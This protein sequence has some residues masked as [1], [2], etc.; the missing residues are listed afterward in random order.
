MSR[1]YVA[2]P[3][4]VVPV[5][6]VMLLIPY[7]QASAAELKILP[8]IWK[9][10]V[11]RTSPMTEGPTTET[12]TECVEEDTFNPT[13]MM[14]GIQGCELVSESLVDTT[15]HYKMA[16]TH[17]DAIVTIEGF[18]QTDGSTGKGNMDMKMNMAGVKVDMN[19]HWAGKRIGDC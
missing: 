16:C 6:M 10:V 13:R 3:D 8:G 18:Y 14:R 11:T 5:V 2:L 7:H 12:S 1:P 9:T 15:L 4:L 17:S 19:M